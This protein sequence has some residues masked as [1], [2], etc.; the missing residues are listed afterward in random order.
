MFGLFK[1]KTEEQKLEEQYRKLLQE[2]RDIQRG[3][4]MKAFAIKSA[5]AE[6]VAKRLEALR[7]AK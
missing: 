2:A 1:K 4:D 3:G 5:E 6:E 7:Q